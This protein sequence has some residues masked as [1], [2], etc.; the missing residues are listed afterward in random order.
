MKYIVPLVMILIA[1]RVASAQ[2]Q[3]PTAPAP[4]EHQA[5]TDY[6]ARSPSDWEFETTVSGGYSNV[7]FNGNNAIPYNPHQGGYVDVNATNNSES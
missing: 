1:C 3:T 6:S 4:P 2:T 7:H 5:L